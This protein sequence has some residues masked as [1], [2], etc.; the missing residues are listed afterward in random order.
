MF[1]HGNEISKEGDSIILWEGHGNVNV[2]K[3]KV[4]EKYNCKRGHYDH[5]DMIGKPWG[6]RRQKKRYKNA[7]LFFLSEEQKFIVNTIE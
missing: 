1:R 2:L 4:G 7:F 6:N 3:L 5:N